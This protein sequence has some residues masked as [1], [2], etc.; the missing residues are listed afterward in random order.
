MLVRNLLAAQD[1]VRVQQ[2]CVLHCTSVACDELSRARLLAR[3]KNQYLKQE[4]I[5]KP[6]VVVPK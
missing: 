6:S 4:T 5:T 1:G 3:A 2:E